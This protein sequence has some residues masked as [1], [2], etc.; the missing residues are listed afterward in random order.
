MTR[1]ITIQYLSLFR[2]YLQENEKSENTVKKYLH[3]LSHFIQ[4]ANGNEVTKSLVLS[5]KEILKSTHALSSANSMIAAINSFFKFMGWDNCCIKQFKIQRQTYRDPERELTKSEYLRL[6]YAAKQNSNEQLNM[7]IQTICST[8]IRVS[9]L[10][11]I[12]VESLYTG[13]VT[14]IN[15]GKVRAI[16][17]SKDLQKLLRRFCK[18]N[19]ISH[20]CIFITRSGRPL[21]R[22]NI[23][24]SMKALCESAHV[25]PAKVFPHNLRHL[26]ARTFYNLDRDI[27]KL[28]DILGHSSIDTTRIYIMTTSSEHIQMLNRM[29]LVI[30]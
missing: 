10:K 11:Y 27:A 20:G 23:W 21:D 14:I 12:S 17:L 7:I 19:N 26:F 30:P 15:K 8:G 25:D 28:A 9:E 6:L 16:L 5:Y 13:K 3:D 2:S 18:R 1:V 4:Y 24:R 22:S 29:N